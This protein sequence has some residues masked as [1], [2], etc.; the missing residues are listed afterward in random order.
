MTNVPDDTPITEMLAAVDE[1]REGAMDRLMDRV[2]ADLVRVADRQLK[3][4]H[5]PELAGITLEPAALANETFLKLI[6]QR[7]RFDS[8]G[9]F[10]AI[11]T[12]VMMRVLNDHYRTRGAAKRGGDMQRVTLS[13]LDIEH[14]DGPEDAIPQFLEAVEQLEKLDARTAEVTKLRLIWGLTIPEIASTTGLSVA[15]AEREWDFARRWLVS[16]L[17]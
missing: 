10:F 7:K 17:T 1:G 5:G 12:K 9:H 8:R 6:K 13:G 16:K 4:R 3:A 15:T 2:Y 14:P 11:A